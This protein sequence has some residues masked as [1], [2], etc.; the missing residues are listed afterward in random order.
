VLR[1]LDELDTIAVLPHRL[2]T[3]SSAVTSGGLLY[4]IY[5]DFGCDRDGSAIVVAGQAGA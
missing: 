5:M 3:L 2:F 1:F 4:W